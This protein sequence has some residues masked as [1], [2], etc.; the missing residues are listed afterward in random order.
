V[1]RGGNER[2]EE[3]RRGRRREAERGVRG[4][5]E[6]GVGREERMIRLYAVRVDS[7]VR[8]PMTCTNCYTMLCTNCYMML[9]L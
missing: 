3:E 4:G 1:D 9:V 5:E 7:A 6:R 8:K 2:R